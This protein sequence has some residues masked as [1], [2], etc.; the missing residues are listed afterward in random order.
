[1][2]LADTSLI[3]ADLRGGD[4]RLWDEM[5]SRFPGRER[6][7]A[8]PT[9]LEIL[10]G[11][12]GPAHWRKLRAYLDIWT[13][14]DLRSEDWAEAA[15]IFYDLRR[16]GITPRSLMDCCIA[17]AAI[18]RGAAI[19]HGDRDFEEIAKVRP[20]AQTRVDWDS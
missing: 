13:W 8:S 1:M 10:I 18:A 15:R 16:R 2:V 3:V 19:L 6:A 14:V 7:I 11:A 4:G 9:A 12:R 20:L 5:E 17:Q